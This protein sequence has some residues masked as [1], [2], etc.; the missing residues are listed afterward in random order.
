M[1]VSEGFQVNVALLPEGSDPDTFVRRQG[2]RAYVERLTTSQPYLEFLL[3]RAV[4]A[5]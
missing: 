3:D 5:A 1:L 4:D 2:G